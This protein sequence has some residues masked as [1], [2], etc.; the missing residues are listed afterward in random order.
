MTTNIGMKDSL[1]SPFIQHV[2]LIGKELRRKQVGRIPM[3]IKGQVK[4]TLK[5][6]VDAEIEN[7]VINTIL[8]LPGEN[9][10]YSRR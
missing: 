4:Q 6:I 9:W 1:A 2:L 10:R 3:V 8:T 7:V 5:E